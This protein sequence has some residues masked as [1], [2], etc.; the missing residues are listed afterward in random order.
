MVGIESKR[1][2]LVSVCLVIIFLVVVCF[3]VASNH[4]GPVIADDV[5]YSV[6]EATLAALYDFEVLYGKRE[7][8]PDKSQW[9]HDF[10]LYRAGWF[11]GKNFT[12][13]HVYNLD[14]AR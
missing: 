6:D 8:A 5:S 13:V 11:S 14:G 12:R 7:D 2:E 9:D 3:V 10:E 4:N 1:S